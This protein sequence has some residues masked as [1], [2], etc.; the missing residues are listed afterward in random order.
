MTD[1]NKIWEDLS[2]A[3]HRD[4]ALKWAEDTFPQYLGNEALVAQLYYSN[5][6]KKNLP[7]PVEVI[8]VAN[9]LEKFKKF[10]PVI[11]P[12]GKESKLYATIEVAMVQMLDDKRG[13]FGCPQCYRKVNRQSGFCSNPD[14]PGEDVKGVSLTFQKWQAGDSTGNIV[15]TFGP[16]AHQKE[17]D[18]K[19]YTLT[20]QGSINNRDGSFNAWEIINKKAP[21]R[22]RALASLKKEESVVK[23]IPEA[24]ILEED[25]VT[26]SENPEE[27]TEAIFGGD[28][29][30]ETDVRD[31]RLTG[32]D[33]DAV[34]RSFTKLLKQHYTKK[35]NTTKNMMNWLGVQPQFRKWDKGTEREAVI[36]AFID[37]LETAGMF[38][39][40][41][42]K[43]ETMLSKLEE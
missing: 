12:D 9:L 10:E 29:K 6:L 36:K 43:H 3:E 34:I 20:I 33:K 17:A 2:I 42:E 18:T 23:V 19:N 27:L 5:V 40:A 11:G 30:G 25:V 22:L 38:V 28:E 26:L 35:P 37:E 14:H 16:S 1:I 32:A 15:V 21:K 39:Y 31:I 41:D 7:P 13:Y 24:V 4:E 8:T